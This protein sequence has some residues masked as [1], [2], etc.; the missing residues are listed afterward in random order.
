MEV[1][2]DGD[3]KR[4]RKRQR[5]AEKEAKKLTESFQPILKSSKS[6]GVVGKAAATPRKLTSYDKDADMHAIVEATA[7]MDH[8][9]IARFFS[10]ATSPLQ[11][12]NQLTSSSSS[13]SAPSFGVEVTTSRKGKMLFDG[14][15]FA[16]FLAT[17]SLTLKRIQEI[18]KEHGFI[19]AAGPFTLTEDKIVE[20][21]L[22]KYAESQQMEWDDLVKFIQAPST[23]DVRKT[24]WYKLT[25]ALECRPLD[26]V[27]RHVR[28]KHSPVARKG[29]FTSAELATLMGAVKTHGTAWI[30]VG[31]IVG[32]PPNIC[33]ITWRREVGKDSQGFHRWWT[34]DE[35]D[36]LMNAVAKYGE[37]NWVGVVRMIPT[38]TPE[39]CANK[40][41]QITG[42]HT[43]FPK[44]L[45]G[46]L[47]QAISRQKKKKVD[48]IK[49]SKVRVDALADYSE[50]RLLNAWVHISKAAVKA[51][52]AQEDFRSQLAWGAA[53]HSVASGDK[54]M[55][56]EKT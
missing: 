2:S 12:F 13:T 35:T 30:V 22:N 29:K 55:P 32:R 39:E 31:G 7:G 56:Q 42:K 17:T 6:K 11:M 44:S 25:R 18:A 41:R 50:R 36:L 38:R 21:F 54:E 47:V 34:S 20:E 40:W 14:L 23:E 46:P 1:T 43:K 9:E 28:T 10:Q 3:E 53:K 19:V 15:T 16:E 5:K 48:R 26:P 49:W 52:I 27:R 45:R 4:A 8:D 33:D 24:F 37:G 51:G